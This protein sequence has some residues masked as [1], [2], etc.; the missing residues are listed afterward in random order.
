M[1]YSSKKSN[2][3]NV[4]Q[5]VH[6]SHYV[7]ENT[8]EIKAF[9]VKVLKNMVYA[10]PEVKTM[11]DGTRKEIVGSLKRPFNGKVKMWYEIYDDVVHIDKIEYITKFGKMDE[12]N[13]VEFKEYS[14]HADQPEYNFFNIIENNWKELEEQKKKEKVESRLKRKAEKI[15]NLLNNL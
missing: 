2:K 8:P 10:K 13:C 4:P 15:A 3:D 14:Y 5:P 6:A 7:S 11:H 1:K 9:V 12:V